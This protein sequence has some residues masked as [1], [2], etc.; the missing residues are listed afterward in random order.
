MPAVATLRLDTQWPGTLRLDVQWPV[1]LAAVIAVADT[2]AVTAMDRFITAT[3]AA[4]TLAVTADARVMATVTVTATTTA[5]V[6]A[7]ATAFPL[8]AVS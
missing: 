5:T 7:P 8:S 2:R 4:I 1:R 6:D 3:K